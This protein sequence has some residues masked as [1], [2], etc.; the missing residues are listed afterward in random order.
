MQA[1][2]VYE[3][4]F[5]NTRAIAYAIGAG[6]AE[7]LD[8][9]VMPVE[10]LPGKLRPSGPRRGRRTSHRHGISR[11]STRRAAEMQVCRPG[12][13]FDT[14]TRRSG[15]GAPGV[16]VLAQPKPGSRTSSRLRYAHPGSGRGDRAR[17]RRDHPRAEAPRL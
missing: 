3:S 14:G 8:V 12:Q 5:A 2:V 6:L 16:D 1:T 9:A 17:V 11:E 7:Y 13:R 15:R 4:M 10:R